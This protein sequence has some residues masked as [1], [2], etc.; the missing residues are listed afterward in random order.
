LN[1]PVIAPRIS[2]GTCFTKKA[3]SATFSMPEAVIRTIISIYATRLS[4][5][6]RNINP[7]IDSA[8]KPKALAMK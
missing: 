2:L 7:A 6:Y 5:L 3:S 1:T 8:L 4:G